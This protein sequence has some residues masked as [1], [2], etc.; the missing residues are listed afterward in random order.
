MKCKKKTF[1]D[2]TIKDTTKFSFY[3]SQ[4]LMMQNQN[5]SMQMQPNPP[6]LPLSPRLGQVYRFMQ[7]SDAFSTHILKF[8]AHL[9]DV[10]LNISVLN[11]KK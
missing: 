4:I 9:W 2:L 8:Q 6:W 3:T 7:F 1:S 11:I 5:S 10:M